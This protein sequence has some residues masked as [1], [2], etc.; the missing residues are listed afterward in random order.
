[1]PVSI[2]HKP[3][4]RAVVVAGSRT[5]FHRAFTQ[6][7]KLDAIDLGAAAVQG[8]LNSTELDRAEVDSIVWGGVIL[9][10]SGPNVGREIGLH[11][12][13]A[14][15]EAMTVSRAVRAPVVT[16]AAAALSGVK[17]M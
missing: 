1:M 3:A 10:S 5:P 14:S 11:S 8:L 2:Q 4:R 9:P 13:P 7:L 17:P 15:V 16:L 12:T 6:L